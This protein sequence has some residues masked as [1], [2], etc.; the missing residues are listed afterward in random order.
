[1][2]WMGDNYEAILL[3]LGDEAAVK[4]RSWISLKHWIVARIQMKKTSPPRR[5]SGSSNP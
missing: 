2:E 4:K 5:G 1:M 3:A